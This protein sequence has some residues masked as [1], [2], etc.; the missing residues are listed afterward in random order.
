MSEP[1]YLFLGFM[2]L[3]FLWR[4]QKSRRRGLLI[5]SALTVGLAFLTRYV[6]G[7]VV[8]SAFAAILLE[9]GVGRR[10]KFGD[11][12]LRLM[13]S[14]PP[15]AAWVIRNLALTGGLTSRQIVWHPFAAS[16]LKRPLALLWEWLLPYEFTRCA[17]LV[18]CAFVGLLLLGALGPS[19][20][21]RSRL[22]MQ[23]MCL[24]TP[25]S[26]LH[27]IYI[28]VYVLSI[29]A[30]ILLLDAATDINDRIA[31]PVYMS[32]VVVALVAAS[33]FMGWRRAG[34]VVKIGVCL[35]ALA[36]V[37]SYTERSVR[38]VQNLSRTPR[39]LGALILQ[40][41]GGLEEVRA[42]PAQTII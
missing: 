25:L 29:V 9:G 10:G 39:G 16:L 31:S 20:V 7:S 30:T 2:G 33:R 4:Y 24:V 27:A 36:L 32:L 26:R 41:E 17:L 1:L 40:Q 19:L 42:I 35:L 18:T 38:L 37:T 12:I 15:M 21:R 3:H 22:D 5:A 11:A 8:A 34:R 6:G 13:F 28:G 23:S 14:L